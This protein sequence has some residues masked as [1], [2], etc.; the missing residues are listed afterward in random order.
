MRPPN[1]GRP[2]VAV[3]GGFHSLQAGR[4]GP[5]TGVRTHGKKHPKVHV[6]TY[7]CHMNTKN[8]TSKRVLPFVPD[9]VIGTLGGLGHC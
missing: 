8:T 4:C 1:G 9:Q 3:L 5:A 2:A 6:E 7:G